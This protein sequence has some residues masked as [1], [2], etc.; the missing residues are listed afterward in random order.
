[1][2]NLRTRLQ[3]ELLGGSDYDDLDDFYPTPKGETK[4][5]TPS[6][7]ETEQGVNGASSE[8]PKRPRSIALAVVA[9]NAVH[10]AY[11]SGYNAG[12]HAGQRAGLDFAESLVP[13]EFKPTYDPGDK[14]F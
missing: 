13:K 2:S 7:D 10:A 4:V 12:F 3:N 9:A 1:M 14:P 5:E 11:E 6:V 8:L